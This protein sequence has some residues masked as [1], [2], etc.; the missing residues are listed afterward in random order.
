MKKLSTYLFLVLFGFSA[1][2]FADD[3]QL[4]CATINIGSKERDGKVKYTEVNPSH[5]SVLSEDLGN[6]EVIVRLFPNE[7]ESGA[8]SSPF[9]GTKTDSS[10]LLRWNSPYDKSYDALRIDRISGQFT[11][12]SYY[13]EEIKSGDWFHRYSGQCWAEEKKF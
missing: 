5:F 10:L 11:L 13:P 7:L 4:T 9:L 2:S 8:M 6:N 1:S 3:V 12:T